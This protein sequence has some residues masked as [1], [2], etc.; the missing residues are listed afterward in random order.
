MKKLMVF[1]SIIGLVSLLPAAEQSVNFRGNWVLDA[2]RSDAQARESNVYSSLVIVQTLNEIQLHITINGRRAYES[3]RLDG[4]DNVNRL[5]NGHEVTTKAKLKGN[6]FEIT[7]ENKY[8]GR[9]AKVTRKY[10]LSKDGKTLNVSNAGMKLVYKKADEA[11]GTASPPTNPSPPAS[12]VK[13]ESYPAKAVQSA[14]KQ[15]D[16]TTA[17]APELTNIGPPVKALQPES[18]AVAAIELVKKQRPADGIQFEIVGKPALKPN[19]FRIREMAPDAI[20]LVNLNN[21]AIVTE[22]AL[23]MFSS[24]RPAR[25]LF[26]S[27]KSFFSKGTLDRT[28]LQQVEKELDSFFAAAMDV[29]R[30]SERFYPYLPDDIRSVLKHPDRKFRMYMP[31]GAVDPSWREKLAQEMGSA[32]SIDG[33]NGWKE[34]LSDDELRLF[35]ALQLDV[36]VQQSFLLFGGIEE[37]AI[38]QANLQRPQT[39]ISNPREFI[40]SLEQSVVQN[41]KLL[42]GTG[43]LNPEHL[44]MASSYMKL[45][46]SQGYLIK[47]VPT[48]EPCPC[49]LSSPAA[50]TLY[51]TSFTS[52]DLHFTWKGGALQIACAALP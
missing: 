48:P 8:S 42:E 15:T 50:A 46:I 45:L 41:K 40:K 6:T 22:Q 4:K 52:L 13:P 21:G 44:R 29:S 25:T 12:V 5:P 39:L 49:F 2:Q 24:N 10:S 35:V 30:G 14:K 47:E 28:E 11:P 27:Q 33:I 31:P 1:L 23:V 17:S 16:A 43:F 18:H 26:S 9:K 7:T 37:K 3:F 34:K 19:A 51:V 38:A 32:N 20:V 36:I